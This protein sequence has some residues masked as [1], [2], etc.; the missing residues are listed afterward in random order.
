MSIILIIHAIA[1]S[2]NYT[3]YESIIISLVGLM[4]SMTILL[5]FCCFFDIAGVD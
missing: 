1:Q 5:W 2:D 3:D 4:S